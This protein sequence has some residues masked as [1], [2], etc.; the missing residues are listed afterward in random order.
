[1]DWRKKPRRTTASI[2][3]EVRI[4]GQ[5]T[6]KELAEKLGVSE[7]TI[8]RWEH[9]QTRIK[10]RKLLHLVKEIEIKKNEERYKNNQ[11]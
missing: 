7:R 3:A 8:R 6:Q 2:Y 11:K 10:G 5:M 1:M 4:V 9:E